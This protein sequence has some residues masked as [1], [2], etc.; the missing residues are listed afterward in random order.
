MKK[1]RHSMSN[2]L[3]PQKREYSGTYFVYDR[4]N[5]EELQRLTVQDRMITAAMGGVFAEQ[6]DLTA[7]HRV[8]D[9][10]C[11]PGGWAIEAARTYPTMSLAGIDISQRMIN[12]ARE[13]AIANQVADRVEFRTMDALL[14]LE[15]PPAYF[16]LANMRF[17]FSFMRT[18]EWHKL[19]SEMQR[20]TRPGGI[21]R[22]TE[23]AVAHESNSPALRQLQDMAVSAFHRAGHLFTQESAGLIPH[24]A[25]LLTQYGVQQVQTK[26]Y[27]LEFRAGTA[28]GRT[29]YEDLMH[30]YHTIRPFLKKWGYESRDYDKIY[31]QAL[32][33]MQQPDFCVTWN[34]LSAWGIAE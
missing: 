4:Q 31:Q 11:G 29:Y 6:T 13:Q 9:I 7:I 21:I 1:D 27:T 3:D 30:V 8:L 14:V 34:L 2:P 25:H 22:L 24:L 10:G 16:D 18:W 26:A 5:Q 33:E 20:V 15:F 19:L 23:T 32:I 12:Y 17:G 28:E